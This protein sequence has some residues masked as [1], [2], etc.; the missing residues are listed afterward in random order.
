M[1][2]VTSHF[3]FDHLGYTSSPL[4]GLFPTPLFLLEWLQD[5]YESSAFVVWISV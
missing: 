2:S 1:T 5:P 3:H 4:T